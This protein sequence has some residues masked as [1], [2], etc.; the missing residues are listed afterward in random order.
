[1]T[2]LAVDVLTAT[3]DLVALRPEWEELWQRTPFATPFQSPHWLLSWWDQFGTEQPRA[4][5]LRRDGQLAGLLPLYILD[6]NGARK[7]LPLGAAMTDYCDA[8]LDPDVPSGSA[9]VLL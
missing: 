7:L 6:E 1:M 5:V 8:L 9:D 4:A 2:R 3:G